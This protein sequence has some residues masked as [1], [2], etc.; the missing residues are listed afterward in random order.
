[1]IEILA[2]KG[3][4]KAVRDLGLAATCTYQRTMK[5]PFDEYY[6]VWEMLSPDFDRL[7]NIPDE[8]WKDNWGW[9]RHANGSNMH[10]PNM[11]YEINNF[12]I[13]AWDGL[14]RDQWKH[15]NCVYCEDRLSGVCKATIEDANFCVGPRQYKNLFTYFCDEIGVS[16]PRNV[17]ALA[18]DLAKY[19]NMTMAELFDRTVG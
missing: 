18:V 13:I 11:V 2:G 7:C 4:D 1:M 14:V 10:T 3:F 6:E 17:C 9:W 19:N 8:E 15:D 12:K 16:A 5:S